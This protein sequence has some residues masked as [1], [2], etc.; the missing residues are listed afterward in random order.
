MQD[1]AATRGGQRGALQF[2]VSFPDSQ[3]IQP[4]LRMI[5][6]AGSEPANINNRIQY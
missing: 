3:R 4:T 2:S 1:K 6:Q 5:S